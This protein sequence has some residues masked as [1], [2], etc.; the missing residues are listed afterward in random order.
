MGF[1]N[2]GVVVSLATGGG[3]FAQPF[4]DLANFGVGAGGW[5]DQDHYPRELAD[6]NG[7]G[8]ADIVGFAN[9]GAVVLLATGGGHFAQP[10][11]DLANFGVGAGG[12]SD[13]THY[14]RVLGDVN[15][16]GRADIVGFANGG[17]VVSLATGGGHFAQPTYELN[18]F[19]VG[20]GG[21]SDQDHYPRELADVNGDGLSDIV[22]FAN[23]GVLISLATGGGH[24]AQPTFDVGNFGNGAGGWSSDSTYP[25]LLG[26]V[27]GDHRADIVAFGAGG[28][29]VA[30]Y[31]NWTIV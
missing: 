23:G 6:V 1:A 25:R 18:N 19:A 28:V 30:E 16:D 31:H 20:A 2:G 29:N 5:S 14:P 8:L 15:G 12:W 3:H 11:Y 24:F 4:Y 9:G 13:Q 26:D 10:F 7:D 21:W 27:S 22:G 17:V